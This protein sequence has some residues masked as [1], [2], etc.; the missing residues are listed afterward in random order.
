MKGFSKKLSL[1]VFLIVFSFIYFTP[2]AQAA[3]GRSLYTSSQTETINAIADKNG[4]D[5]EL[6]AAM[7]NLSPLDKIKSG[8]SIWL[9]E[10]PENIVT[11]KKGDTLWDLSKQYQTTVAVLVAKNNL[12]D[13]NQLKIGQSL[14]VPVNDLQEDPEPRVVTAVISKK[15]TT[16][17]RGGSY[18]WPLQGIITSKYGYR[19]SGF[20]H[21]LDIAAA[22]GTNIAAI[23]GGKV[24]QVGWFSAIYGN[25]ITIDHGNKE[26]S[27]YAHLS[28]ILVEEGQIVSQGQIIGKVG[29][30]G[31]A[32]GPHLHLQI[33]LDG[34]T[35]DPIKYL[36]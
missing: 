11:V 32:T 34:K 24:T 35:V 29:E 22:I 8:Q 12:C 31:N 4:L 2:V 13:A 36:R 25:T 17:S 5:A 10:D 21:G 3:D 15:Y 26:E 28:K 9:P 19:S 1:F 7:N 20:H 33:N 27:F 18:A 6:V 30:T 23:K 16:A 14:K